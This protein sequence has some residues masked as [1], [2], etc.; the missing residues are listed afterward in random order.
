MGWNHDLQSTEDCSREQHQTTEDSCGYEACYE[1]IP[2]TTQ[3][4]VGL[5]ACGKNLSN[6]TLQCDWY[7]YDCGRTGIGN[8]V[9]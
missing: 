2:L 9:V 6:V 7:W 1:R 5:D 4:V 3:A 8:T